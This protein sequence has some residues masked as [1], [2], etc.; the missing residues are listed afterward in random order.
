M[1]ELSDGH[2]KFLKDVFPG[3]RQ[4]YR[5]LADH[6]SPHTLFIACAD[7]RIVPHLILQAGPEELFV[8]RN[9][10]N[11]V[12]PASAPCEGTI[13]TVEYAV[14]VLHV[15]DIVI[16]GHSDCGAVKTV[17]ENKDL[18][19]LPATA[20]WL[21]YIERPDPTTSE[22]D[23][24]SRHAALVRENAI[25]QLNHLKTH[26]VVSEALARGDLRLHA[27]SY[28]IPSGGIEEYDA[29]SGR[30]VPLEQL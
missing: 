5:E 26:A 20:Q 23:F 19:A 17:L 14:A 8:C 27:W 2:G 16:C 28:D 6:Q 11:I 4:R 1:S 30:F 10:G 21:R 29:G 18:S 15:R 3:L 13:C 25:A 12:P 24:Q 22:G 7:S 9:V